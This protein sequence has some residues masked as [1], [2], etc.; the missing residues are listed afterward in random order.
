VGTIL[1]VSPWLVVARSIQFA[2]CILLFGQLLFTVAIAHGGGLAQRGARR[3][4]IGC[5]V[6]IVLSGLAWLALVAASVT[7]QPLAQLEP[8]ALWLMLTATTFGHLWMLRA[9]LLL[10]VTVAV[11]WQA[12]VLALVAAAACLASLAWAGHAAAGVGLQRVVELGSDVV[13][14]MAAGAWL[15]ALPALAWMLAHEN[16]RVR[17]HRVVRRFSVYGVASAAALVA[18]GALNAWYRVG[19]VAALTQSEYGRLLLAKLALVAAMVALAACNRYLWT[20][21]LLGRQPR[22]LRSLRRNTLLEIVAGAGVIAIVGALGITVPAAHGT[23]QH[24]MP[25]MHMGH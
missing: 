19:S 18:T 5:V 23:M 2:G 17:L 1:D 10:L 11:G 20:P 22:A 7:G 12:H 3:V 25:A 8:H 16:D 21:R 24:A 4:S 14:L 15:G 13:H 9:A 6:V